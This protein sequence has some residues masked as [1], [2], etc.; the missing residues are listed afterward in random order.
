M[1]I[2]ECSSHIFHASFET[3]SKTRW[4]ISPFHGTRSSPSIVLPNFTHFTVRPPGFDDACGACFKGL[5]QSSAIKLS[6]KR[7]F[8]SRSFHSYDTAYTSKLPESRNDILA[9]GDKRGVADALVFQTATLHSVAP[10]E[11]RRFSPG[12]QGEGPAFRLC[13]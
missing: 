3:F 6:C 1:I 8:N 5:L 10:T 9:L 4:P 11:P 2:F 13:L 7:H 12:A